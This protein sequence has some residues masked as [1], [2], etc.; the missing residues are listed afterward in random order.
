[1][2]DAPLSGD[3]LCA[4]DQVNGQLASGPLR[5]PRLVLSLTGWAF[6]RAEPGAPTEVFALLTSG[7][8]WYSIRATRV[9]RPDVAAVFKEPRFEMS[10]YTLQGSIVGLPPG[11]YRVS[12]RQQRGT[13]FVSCDVPS[14]IT[15]TDARH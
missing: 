8:H 2:V 3:A 13:G 6:D 4:L 1:L 5:T 14:V 12:I 9:A 15:V 7:G 11:D 10:G